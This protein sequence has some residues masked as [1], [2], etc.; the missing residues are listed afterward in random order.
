LSELAGL[1][2][3]EANARRQVVPPPRLNVADWLDE[4]RVIGREYPSPYPGPWRTDRTPYLREPL[5]AWVDPAVETIVL[6]FSSQIGKTEALMGW[7]LYSYGVDPGPGMMV[8]PTLDLAGAM[9]SDRV[10]HALASCATLQVGAPKA[11]GGRRARATDN[12]ILH[13]RVN[14]L[15]LTLSGANSAAS[16]S[17]RPVRYLLGDE[18]DRWPTTTEEGDPLNLALQRTR[19]FRRR[20]VGWSSTPTIKGSSRIEDLY[21]RSDQQVLEAPC[22]RCAEY[23]EVRW[24]HVKWTSGQPATAHLVHLLVDQRTGEMVGCGGSIDERERAAMYRAAR[25]R[26]TAPFAGIRGFKAWSIANTWVPL[27]T[28]V[29]EFLVARERPETLQAWTNLT[30]GESWEP[31]AQR[32]DSASLLMRREN[33]PAAA[34]VPVG[35][36]VLTAGVDT[37]DDR[38]EALCVGWGPGE[39]SW[40]ISRETFFGDPD[41]DAVWQE[42]DLF[43]LR[44]WVREAGGAA[45]IQ[46]TLVDA[47]GH[48]T[49]A[50]YKAIVARQH[51]RVFASFGRDGGEKGQTGIVTTPK[52]QATPQG[53][54]SKVI[55]DASQAKGLI[56]SRLKIEAPSGP[57]VLHFPMSVG[58]AFF[59]ELTAEE[60]LTTRNRWNVPTRHWALRPGHKRNETLDCYG[61]A[62][63]ALRIICPNEARFS[64]MAASV[65][66]AAG[67]T[68]PPSTAPAGAP[69]RRAPRT[70]NWSRG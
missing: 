42:L 66:A 32:I 5:N 52:L 20:K 65:A 38:L 24:A 54:V 37:Q 19:S 67:S 8:L 17:S 39:E 11:G 50:V 26:A 3:V 68:P 62:L 70:R 10:S 23:F 53:N 18:V 27:A 59:T 61:L 22:P 41:T 28:M 13:K 63:A 47:L 36:Q 14:G 51:R 69:Q 21:G 46:C 4:H 45:K 25:W 12:A 35:A 30:L 44:A 2:R 7:L 64:A 6:Q 16:L 1:D 9:S 58:D 40:V 43:L 34:D 29:A 31:P 15:P 57:G 48:R 60:L 33:Y 55:V 56:Y 49:S